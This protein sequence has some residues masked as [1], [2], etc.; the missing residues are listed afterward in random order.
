M[1]GSF[2]R[3]QIVSK[4]GVVSVQGGVVAAQHVLAA[5]AGADVLAAGGDAVDAAVATS[6]VLGVLEPWMSGPMGGGAMMIW[7][8]D[9]GRAHALSYGMRASRLLERGHY[10]LSG[11][12]RASDLFPWESVVEDRN[13]LGASAVAVPGT[14]AGHRRRP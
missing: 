11:T 12:G 5:Q 2:S 4:P 6:F 8:E 9:E 14:V 10:P 1:A 13:I 3:S 7:R